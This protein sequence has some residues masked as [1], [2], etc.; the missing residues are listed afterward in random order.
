MA[1]ALSLITPINSPRAGHGGR[2]PIQWIS[3]RT[4]KD[5]GQRLVSGGGGWESNPP[6]GASRRTGFE[7]SCLLRRCCKPL[8]GTFVSA[9]VQ[10][11]DEHWCGRL[12]MP[13]G[14]TRNTCAVTS[15]ERLVRHHLLACYPTSERSRSTSGRG[16]GSDLSGVTSAGLERVAA[17]RVRRRRPPARIPFAITTTSANS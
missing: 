8:T 10:D 17:T 7:D 15:S 6:I 9:T 1:G 5:A 13:Q 2:K 14:R 4:P 3:G 16:A 11:S 12:C